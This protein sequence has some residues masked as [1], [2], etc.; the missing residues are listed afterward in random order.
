MLY[1]GIDVAK[2]KHDCFIIDSD[3][4]VYT[5]NLRIP[6]NRAG[7]NRLLETILNALN[8]EPV[9][10]AK[11][12]LEHKW[13]DSYFKSILSDSGVKVTHETSFPA[14]R[15]SRKVKDFFVPN[16]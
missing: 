15:L 2:S 8:G 1:I 11:A 7:F 4:A 3:G 6:N 14:H 5:D 12:G 16:H 9:K 13:I 10:N